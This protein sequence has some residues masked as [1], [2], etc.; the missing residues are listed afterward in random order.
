MAPKFADREQKET[1]M[2]ALSRK[3]GKYKTQS[4][5]ISGE[6]LSRLYNVVLTV[7]IIVWVFV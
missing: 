7:I 2:A 4:V 1:Y 5:L 3:W 6:K